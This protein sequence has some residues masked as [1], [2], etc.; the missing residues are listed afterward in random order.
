[1][2]HMVHALQKERGYSAGFISTKGA[3]NFSGSL[4]DQVEET[5]VATKV[6]LKDFQMFDGSSYGDEFAH[7]SEL[8][9]QD[10]QGISN[11]R[12]KVL[13][14]SITVPEMADY[15]TKM[16]NEFLEIINA[17]EHHTTD[18]DL[19][20]VYAAYSSLLYMKEMAGLERAKG[21]AILS[22]PDIQSKTLYKYMEV[23]H[24]QKAYEESFIHLSSKDLI[25][26]FKE[27]MVGDSLKKVADVRKELLKKV[28]DQSVVTKTKAYD[29]F[30]YS[31]N[32]IELIADV[33]NKILEKLS[34]TA[35]KKLS[36][37]QF[38][39]WFSILFW[40]SILVISFAFAFATNYSV[41]KKLRSVYQMFEEKVNTSVQS[42]NVMAEQLKTESESMNESAVKA[43]EIGS[44]VSQEA[45]DTRSNVDLTIS[46]VDEMAMAADEISSSIIQTAELSTTATENAKNS[47]NQIA[48]LTNSMEKI[49]NMVNMIDSLADQTNLLALNAAIESARAGEA[50]RGFAVVA[51]EVK[52][53]ASQTASSTEA[54][55]SEVSSILEQSKVSVESINVVV[56]AI[57]EVNDQAQGISS[58]SE[59]Q[60]AIT[61]NVKSSAGIMASKNTGV[62]EKVLELGEH[63]ESLSISISNLVQG[64]STMTDS[65]DILNESVVVLKT[66][67]K[68]L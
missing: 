33:E 29:W 63:S 30:N 65:I 25:H 23:Y 24:K 62:L 26:N 4:K 47:G 34:Y 15:Y 1:V 10:L 64:A 44:F 68:E 39:M 53:L 45:E 16:I 17:F 19:S 9:I 2:S 14:L 54:I 55:E 50:G 27:I 66:E 43:A 42:I 60:S 41:R 51:E 37:A 40:F 5:D 13:N 38:A 6:F 58:A 18:N 59:E 28:F 3:A 49:S 21:S 36:D 11:M 8:A 67:L 22:N 20:K 32:R 48:Q 56:K 46:A 57:Q 61:L 12:Q 31:T 35:E 7:N 52:K